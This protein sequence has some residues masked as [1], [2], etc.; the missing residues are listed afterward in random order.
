MV[1][2]SRSLF[3]QVFAAVVSFPQLTAAWHLTRFAASGNSD[4]D[5]MA[6]NLHA[7]NFCIWH[8]EDTARRTDLVDGEVVRC[9]RAIDSLNAKRNAAIEAL[10]ERLLRCV[11]AKRGPRGSRYQ[12]E[13]AGMLIDRLSIL[14]LRTYHTN[15]VEARQRLRVLE[16]QQRHLIDSLSQLMR[17][18]LAGR[19]RY[20]V[21]KQFKVPTSRANDCR[22]VVDINELADDLLLTSSRGPVSVRTTTEIR[23]QAQQSV[24]GGTLG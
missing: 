15:R 17:E 21:Y 14:S 6:T 5:E 7:I 23:R 16:I 12:S 11:A 9:K 1:S 10:D 24:L 22:V 13:T 20:R 19:V 2:E 18:M 4:P 3:A 8:F